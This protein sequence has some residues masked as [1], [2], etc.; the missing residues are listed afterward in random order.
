MVVERE[1]VDERESLPFDRLT[2]QFGLWVSLWSIGGRTGG[3]GDNDKGSGI[4]LGISRV[5]L[6]VRRVVIESPSTA[7]IQTEREREETESFG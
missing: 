4:T 6:D 3:S 7:A 5:A 2:H 1:A